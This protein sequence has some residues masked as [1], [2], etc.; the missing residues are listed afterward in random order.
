MGREFLPAKDAELV[1]WSN[2]LSSMLSTGFATYGITSAQ[3]TAFATLNTAWVAAYNLAANDGTRTPA[4]I[5]TKNQARY[6]MVQN[7]RVL[8]GIIQKFPGTTNTMRSALGL[9]VE[10]VRT[11]IPPPGISPTIDVLSVDARN[12]KLRIHAG[13]L[14]RGKPAGVAGMAVFSYVGATPPEDITAWKFEGNTTVTQFI[15]AFDAATPAFSRVWLTA[16]FFNPRGQSGMACEPISTYLGSWG[17]SGS[18]TMADGEAA[19]KAA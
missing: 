2:N 14:R 15:V 5:I 9:T 16:F 8:A 13:S 6:N 4:A 3:A 11:P 19:R 18:L 7:A 17:S 12:V 1:T 10:R